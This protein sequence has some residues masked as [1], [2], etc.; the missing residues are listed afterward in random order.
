MHGDATQLDTACTSKAASR[1]FSTTIHCYRPWQS[2]T[3]TTCANAIDLVLANSFWP[4][5][6]A[7]TIFLR[8]C[9]VFVRRYAMR[10]SWN[11]RQE[12]IFLHVCCLTYAER[13]DVLSKCYRPL[14]DDIARDCTP[15]DNIVYHAQPFPGAASAAKHNTGHALVAAYIC[16]VMS[17]T[18]MKAT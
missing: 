17:L 16:I 13:R 18:V 9:V 12:W 4:S 3:L 1:A 8:S 7:Q 11:T 14:N 5:C 6:L 10:W 2:W 15:R